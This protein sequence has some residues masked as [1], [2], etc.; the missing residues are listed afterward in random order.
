M[1]TIWAQKPSG[2]QPDFEYTHHRDKKAL[3][4]LRQWAS[5]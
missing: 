1:G 4:A 3:R 2:K 5:V